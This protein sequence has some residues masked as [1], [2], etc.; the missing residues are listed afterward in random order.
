MDF[1]PGDTDAA[2]KIEFSGV[3]DSTVLRQA[4]HP[5]SRQVKWSVAM[6]STSTKIAIAILAVVA[7]APAA[8]YAQFARSAGSAA[9]G[10]VPISGIAGPGKRGR[11]EQC[12]GRSERG[13][14]RCP[15]SRAA[16]AAHK[17]PGDSEVQMI[18]NAAFDFTGP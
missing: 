3:D 13:R 6:S 1:D 17:R 5:A 12:D 16:A 15:G 14:Q 2:S 7:A 9:A 8:S 10:N 4:M 11:N 18:A